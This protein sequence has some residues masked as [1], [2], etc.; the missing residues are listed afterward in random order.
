MN[1]SKRLEGICCIL[2][3]IL[4]HGLNKCYSALQQILS[5]EST[6]SFQI[7][8]FPNCS[9]ELLIVGGL[10]MLWGVICLIKTKNT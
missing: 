3:A 7:S 10:L 4:L 5:L 1:T 9:W 6:A 2:C 8:F